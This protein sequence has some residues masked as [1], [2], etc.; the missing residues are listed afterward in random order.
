MLI[1]EG[2]QIF[3]TKGDDGT[4]EM[5][6][7]VDGKPYQMQDGDSLTFTVRELPS[8]ESP[9]LIEITSESNNIVLRH[10]DTVN[11]PVAQYSADA[12]VMTSD[13]K[14]ITVWPILKGSARKRIKNWKNFIVMPEVTHI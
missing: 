12:Q 8:E 7:Q 13:G 5:G 3:I 9:V 14:R 1:I 4:V 10:E 2:N 11:L 6:L